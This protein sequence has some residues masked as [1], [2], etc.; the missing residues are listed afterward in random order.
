MFHGKSRC[1]GHGFESCH[2]SLEWVAISHWW[3]SQKKSELFLK[4]GILWRTTSN[5]LESPQKDYHHYQYKL[6]L[7]YREQ[8]HEV[9]VVPVKDWLITA[10][11]TRQL[12]LQFLAVLPTSA[13][14]KKALSMKQPKIK[15]SSPA[16]KL[17][18]K[19]F[20]NLWG[21]P[22]FRLS[23]SVSRSIIL[24]PRRSPR[25]FHPLISGCILPL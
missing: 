8:L 2:C 18:E 6:V 19:K 20:G 9:L 24:V 13:R 1:H 17:V 12:R 3:S 15:I 22:F 4:G 7:A 21:Y 23:K 16:A 11:N 10:T 25:V 5:S 14:R